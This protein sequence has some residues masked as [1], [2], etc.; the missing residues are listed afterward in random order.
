MLRI[1]IASLKKLL[2]V[3]PVLVCLG[4][5][6]AHAAEE[7]SGASTSGSGQT[8]LDR[9]AVATGLG[10]MELSQAFPDAAVW[11]ALEDGGRALGLFYPERKSPAQGALVILADVGANAASGL[12]GALN[13]RLV[14]RGWAV[15]SIGLP[16]PSK[17]LQRALEAEPDPDP[18]R[19]GDRPGGTGGESSV[20][21][22][23]M[24]DPD[25]RTP[26][27]IYRSRIRQSLE[28]AVAALTARGY[29]RPVL[30]GV[31]RAST[32][33]VG[34]LS[35]LADPRALVWVLPEFYPRDAAALADDLSSASAVAILEL[36]AS[37]GGDEAAD[38][39]WVD[40]RRAGIEQLERQPVSLQRPPAPR[41][42]HSLASRIDA[43]LRSPE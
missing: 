35:G 2:S 14:E 38:Q 12:A 3:L 27:Q 15:L 6:G 31:G 40:L 39:R 21:I 20:M 43:W 23:V 42:A 34:A 32:H 5:S 30:V 16:A 17:P 25:S 22:D 13:L 7:L 36:Y 33:L 29:D 10:E 37:G 41:D 8:A 9:S 28:A 1:G 19:P 4:Y 24:A 11:L 26:E 18:D